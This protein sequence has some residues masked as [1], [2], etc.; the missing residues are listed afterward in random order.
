M[1]Y[2][3]EDGENNW[4]ACMNVQEELLHYPGIGISVS[5][6]VKFVCTSFLYPLFFIK[7]PLYTTKIFCLFALFTFASSSCMPPIKSVHDQH[8]KKPVV[9]KFRL[10]MSRL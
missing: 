5:K 3:G 9:S 4:L 8:R 1:V 10:C 6:M 7:L 2:N